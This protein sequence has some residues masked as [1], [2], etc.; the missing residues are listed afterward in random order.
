MIKLCYQQFCLFLFAGADQQEVA[1]YKKAPVSQ[2][3]QILFP[4]Q[5]HCA[6]DC[7]RI[8]LIG[9]GKGTDRRHFLSGFSSPGED[10]VFQILFHLYVEWF[11]MPEV[12][13]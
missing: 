1:C 13:F 12:H 10:G 9:G 11:V 4:Q 3:D 6:L 8:D 5:V 2:V 7:V